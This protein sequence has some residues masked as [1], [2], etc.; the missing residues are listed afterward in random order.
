M[1]CDYEY[2]WRQDSVR[3]GTACKTTMPMFMVLEA[4][5]RNQQSN[6]TTVSHSVFKTFLLFFN[7]FAH[8]LNYLYYLQSK[9]FN[10][11]VT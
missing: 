1:W 10:L 8:F 9:S 7:F 11:K 5:M 2:L 4:H 6:A 3:G